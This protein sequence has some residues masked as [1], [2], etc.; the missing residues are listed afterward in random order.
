MMMY[1]HTSSYAPQWR[2]VKRLT[3]FSQSRILTQNMLLGILHLE[4]V[5]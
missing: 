1:P 5:F 3:R 2:G 4:Q